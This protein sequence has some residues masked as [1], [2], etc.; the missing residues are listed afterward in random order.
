MEKLPIQELIEQRLA[1]LGISRSQLAGRVGYNRI[2]KGLRKLDA[3]MEGDTRNNRWISD[4]LP[5][6]QELPEQTIE[7]ALD[8]TTA[9]LRKTADDLWR[10][11]FKPNCLILT[12]HNGR[13][14]QITI[15]ALV[16]AG[17]HVC[18]QIPDDIPESNYCSYVRERL[19]GWLVEVRKFFHAPTGYIINYT[20]DKATQF[21]LDGNKV[22]DLDKAK[23]AGMLTA[24]LR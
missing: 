12:E 11:T 4:R 3:L 1:E 16:G 20:P 21:D 24:S 2:A 15:A 13:P 6:A 17:R 8:E 14:R 9:L 19:D 22:A 18:Q 23:R 7:A 5:A 10:S